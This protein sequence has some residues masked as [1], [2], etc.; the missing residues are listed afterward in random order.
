MCQCPLSKHKISSQGTEDRYHIPSFICIYTTQKLTKLSSLLATIDANLCSPANSEIR[1]TYSGAVTWF[2]LWVRPETTSETNWVVFT[3]YRVFWDLFLAFN[4]KLVSRNPQTR[5]KLKNV[6][7]TITP[8]KVR[9]QNNDLNEQQ[10]YSE[11]CLPLQGNKNC[12]A[13]VNG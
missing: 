12:H 8:R 10:P 4:T 7:I 5:G 2:D 3:T 11:Q 6:N 13:T 1:K 9:N